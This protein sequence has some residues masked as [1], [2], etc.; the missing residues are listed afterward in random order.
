MEI[1][2]ES[3]EKKE[4]VEIM[5]ILFAC[6]P[7]FNRNKTENFADIWI[8]RLIEEGD[9]KLTIKKVKEHTA[10]NPYPPSLA[11]IIARKY[12]PVYTELTDIEVM[13]EAVRREKADPEKA[14]KREESLKRFEEK[15]KELRRIG[16]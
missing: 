9:Y 6:Y 12:K 15:I 3:M 10:S 8:T 4:A 2:S 13:E 5:E 11:D 16:R 14:K 7:N 1:R